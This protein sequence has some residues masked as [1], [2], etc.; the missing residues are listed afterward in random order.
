MSSFLYFICIRHK[1]LIYVILWGY[2]YSIDLINKI[3]LYDVISHEQHFLTNFTIIL[4]PSFI[5]H[6]G[7]DVYK[8]FSF[9]DYHLYDSGDVQ[10][11]VALLVANLMLWMPIAFAIQMYAIRKYKKCKSIRMMIIG[12]TVIGLTYIWFYWHP[13]LVGLHEHVPHFCRY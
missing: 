5:F 1:W 11:F 8:T 4:N 12:V 13:C 3:I 2:A 9:I 10:F 6:I 7:F